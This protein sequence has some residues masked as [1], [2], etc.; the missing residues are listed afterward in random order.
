MYEILNEFVLKL[1]SLQIRAVVYTGHIALGIMKTKE[2]LEIWPYI[3]GCTAL[4]ISAADIY[5]E[6]CEIHGTSTMSKRSVF[7]WCKKN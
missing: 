2:N 1:L 5:S 4:K 6:L 3:K 7:K